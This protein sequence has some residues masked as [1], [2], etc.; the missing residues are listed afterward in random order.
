[1]SEIS[2][3]PL[4]F[5]ELKTPVFSSSK[6]QPNVSNDAWIFLFVG[7][8]EAGMGTEGAELTSRIVSTMSG[9]ELVAFLVD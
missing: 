1:M 3:P 9:F 4:K 6:I 8:K 5:P 2:L 7:V